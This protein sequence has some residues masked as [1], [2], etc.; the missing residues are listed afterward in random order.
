MR[1][2]RYKRIFFAAPDDAGGVAE[3]TPLE[4]FENGIEPATDPVVDPAASAV[5]HPAA[6]VIDPAAPAAV[7]ATPAA[8]DY[9]AIAKAIRDGFGA[10]PAPSAPQKE[11]TQAEIDKHFNVYN[12]SEA[13]LT[14]VLAGGPEA[15]VAL[16]KILQ[17]AVKQ[18]TTIGHYA[19]MKQVGEFRNEVT[20]HLTA[21]QQVAQDASKARFFSANKD[22]EGADEVLE[23]VTAQLQK[24][25]AFVGMK[26]E[27]EV[28]TA[29]AVRAKALMGKFTGG[30]L[31]VVPG[32][33][34][35]KKPAMVPLA[36][37]RQAGSAAPAGGGGSSAGGPKDIFA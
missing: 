5:A 10:A 27:K 26:T 33:A 24:E 25:N 4:G 21:A 13:D 32:A 34:G 22:L 3:P 31:A 17:G 8:P 20:P 18:A 2:T 36:G 14:A 23:M 30:V 28:H 11:W 37:G 15:V 9:A 1:L 6:V 29:I 19:A 16:N 12:A 7:P 35:A